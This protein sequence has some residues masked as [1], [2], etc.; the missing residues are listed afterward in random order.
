MTDS[1]VRYFQDSTNLIVLPIANVN[2]PRLSGEPNSPDGREGLKVKFNI[3]LHNCTGLMLCVVMVVTQ[4]ITPFMNALTEVILTHERK[5][6]SE[7]SALLDGS[8]S[9][10]SPDTESPSQ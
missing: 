2:S 5:S 8:T 6:K 1:E 4:E 7:L 10:L 3:W 9:N